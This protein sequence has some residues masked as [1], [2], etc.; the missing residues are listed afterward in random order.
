M[1]FYRL[2]S[3]PAFLLILALFLN[4]C[5][6]TTAKHPPDHFVK[7]DRLKWELKNKN[8]IVQKVDGEVIQGFFQTVASDSLKWTPMSRQFLR[9][10]KVDE[11]TRLSLVLH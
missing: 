3:A 4:S 1:L 5:T 6:S 11:G 9:E 10:V 7:N 2:S 8:V